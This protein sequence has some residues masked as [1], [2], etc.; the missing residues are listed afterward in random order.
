MKKIVGIVLAAGI[1]SRMDSEIDK[2]FLLINGNDIV[3]P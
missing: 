1:G 3:F 2:Q